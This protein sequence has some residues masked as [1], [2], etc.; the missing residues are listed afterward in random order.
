MYKFNNIQNTYAWIIDTINSRVNRANW[1]IRVGFIIISCTLVDKR[2]IIRW[3]DVILAASRTER[4][5][6][7]INILI[8]S[9]ITINLIMG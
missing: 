8:D 7:R 9:I 3:P 5:S 1:I 6:G 2:V 4:V